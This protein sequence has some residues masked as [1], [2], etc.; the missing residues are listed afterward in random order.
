[1]LEEMEAEKPL[2][3]SCL[4]ID[5]NGNM[6]TSYFGRLEMFRWFQ[7]KSGDGLL[8]LPTCK[9]PTHGTRWRIR[10]TMYRIARAFL[11]CKI[12][13]P[14]FY[15]DCFLPSNPCFLFLLNPSLKV[16]LSDA[17]CSH[18]NET[19]DKPWNPVYFRRTDVY[20]CGR[21]DFC[22]GSGYPKKPLNYA[23][24]FGSAYLYIFEVE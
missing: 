11:D 3:W 9:Q 19:V 2:V 10:W 20:C 6:A 21:A 15:N 18:P 23:P 1:M 4:L 24:N 5:L 16:K 22:R 13:R 17:S 12:D 8:L 14:S 7:V